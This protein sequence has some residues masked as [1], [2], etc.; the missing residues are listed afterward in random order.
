MG[1][2]KKLKRIYFIPFCLLIFFCSF[3]SAESIT[4]YTIKSVVPMN[5]NQTVSGIYSTET[6]DAN[7]LVLCSFS[8]VDVNGILI[9]RA[10]D[11]YP[12]S[13]GFFST[14]FKVSEPLMKRGNDY[15]VTTRCGGVSDSNTFR[16]DL[17][18]SLEQPLIA[19]AFWFMDSKNLIPLFYYGVGLILSL[20]FV[21][22]I[23]I[24]VKYG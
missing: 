18:E 3:V 16:V 9:Y 5:T 17:P 19:N 20:V 10:S 12:Q 15:N 23:Y 24:R 6:A 22:W 4:N 7:N 13:K 1:K 11:Q 2:K 14:E 21:A 8:V